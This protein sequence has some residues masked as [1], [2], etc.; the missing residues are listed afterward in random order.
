MPAIS[1]QSVSKTF[2]TA[3]GP[4]QALDGVRFDIEQGEFFGLLGPNGAGKTTLISILAGLAKATSGSV[5]VM[6]VNVNTQAAEARK[7]LGVVPN[8]MKIL[9]SSPAAL[10]GYL[11]LNET[12]AKGTLGAKTG[13]RIALAV[14]EFNRCGYCLA[15]HTYLAGR[16][17]RLD[18]AEI[19]AN[20][21]GRSNDAKADAAVRFAAAGFAASDLAFTAGCLALTAVCLAFA[22]GRLAFAAGG[23]ADLRTT[24]LFIF[25]FFVA[26]LALSL[27][28]G[29]VH[30]GVPRVN[31]R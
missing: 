14:A 6:G 27:P 30:F 24:L 18:A 26:I 7:K 15:A 31:V 3:R 4:F 8:L 20:R 25:C 19:A 21:A 1:F 11:G 29:R 10:G 5:S 9:S 17:A 16:L 13:E 28:T 2:Q 23:L 12:L 22:A